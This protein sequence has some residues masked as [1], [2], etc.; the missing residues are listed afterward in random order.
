[1]KNFFLT[2]DREFLECEV[3]ESTNR[4]RVVKILEKGHAL[5]GKTKTLPPDGVALGKLYPRLFE[6][7]HKPGKDEFVEVAGRVLVRQSTSKSLV[8]DKTT[9]EFVAN[10]TSHVI[11][12][13][14]AG[15]N[16]LLTGEAGT[17]KTSMIE[18][19]AARIGQP[20]LRV[21]LNGETRIGDFLGRLNVIAGEKGSVTEWV[22]GILPLAMKNGMWL[23]LDEI[24]MGEPNILSLLHPILEPNGRLVLKENKGEEVRPHPNFRIFGTANG[25]GSQGGRSDTY[26]G[27]NQMNEAFLDRW[28]IITMPSLDAKTE[29]KVIKR[30][31]PTLP[32]KFAKRIVQFGQSIR[33]GLEN[34]TLSMTF[35]TRRALQ[36]AQKL[37]LYRNPLKAAEAVFLC[38]VSPEDRTVLE[39]QIQLIFGSGK[40]KGKVDKSAVTDAATTL[41]P[42]VKGKRGRPKKVQG[43]PIVPLMI[44]QGK[45]GMFH[46]VTAL[47]PGQVIVA[48][49]GN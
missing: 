31:Y 35:S 11:D 40:R 13:I 42:K 22:D 5:S 36:W 2:R 18:Q 41:G 30:R 1:M 28:H 32:P 27:V 25:I 39:K 43:A 12:S 34:E 8:P 6:L 14:H 4:K 15:D 46:K 29:I 47:K 21:N 38:K 48:K 20:V 24:D 3:L 7:P 10:T 23:I 16:I 19:L 9:Y 45:D 33:K 49:P 26:A 44:A 37:A 17:G